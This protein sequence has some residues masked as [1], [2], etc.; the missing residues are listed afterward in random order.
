MD[1]NQQIPDA[2]NAPNALQGLKIIVRASG[3]AR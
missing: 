2:P 1:N 3:S